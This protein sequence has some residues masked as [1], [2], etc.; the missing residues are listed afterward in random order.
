[1]RDNSEP[2]FPSANE[3]YFGMSLR[4][5]IAIKAMAAVIMNPETQR[6]LANMGRDEGMKV[7]STVAYMQ[8]DAMLAAREIV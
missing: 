4:D 3:Q 6:E 8:A 2:A 7:I 1:M 5:Y